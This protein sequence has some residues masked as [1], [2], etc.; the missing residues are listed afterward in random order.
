MLR[1][2]D[3]YGMLSIAA[4]CACWRHIARNYDTRLRALHHA[5]EHAV[6]LA[7]AGRTC[8]TSWPI[9]PRSRCTPSRPSGNCIRNITTDHLAGGARPTSWSTP[10]PGARSSASGPRCI[11][12]S[13]SC[14]ASSRSRSPAPRHDRAAVRRA[15]HR[16][17]HAAAATRARSVSEVMVGGGLGRTPIDRQPDPRVPAG[18]DL[19]ELPGGDPARLQPARPPRQHLQ[20][21]HQDPGR[22]RWAAKMFA[23]QV[24]AEWQHI[25]ARRA[26]TCPRTRSRRIAAY[27]ARRRC[28][29]AALGQEFDACAA[30]RRATARS[31]RWVMRN[32]LSPTSCRATPS[33]PSR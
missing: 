2:A 1:V 9:S 3:P 23:R 16:P 33:S 6:Q 10:R 32:T 27:F 28:G 25:R 31:A 21:A 19:L 12:N 18:E 15:R 11:R 8:R 30:A 17:A 20:G 22:T 29:A 14:R 13:P 26:A 5:P 4:S 7:E 24:E